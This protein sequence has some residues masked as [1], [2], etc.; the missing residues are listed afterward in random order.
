[1]TVWDQPPVYVCHRGRRLERATS[2]IVLMTAYHQLHHRQQQ[3]QQ[4]TDNEH[5]SSLITSNIPC[6]CWHRCWHRWRC[7]CSSSFS[8]RRIR[9]WWA[10]P[11]HG[12]LDRL[13]PEFCPSLHDG[14]PAGKQSRFIIQ[15]ISLC[16]WSSDRNTIGII[17]SRSIT[18]RVC[19]C[20]DVAVRLAA[21]DNLKIDRPTSVYGLA[22]QEFQ[23][24]YKITESFFES[25]FELLDFLLN[26]IVHQSSPNLAARVRVRAN[27][28][29][30]PV[31]F[32]ARIM[33][34][35]PLS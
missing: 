10:A 7:P 14:R 8:A 16:C 21:W 5:L 22:L 1:M 28:V 34:N 29:N 4:S 13:N 32:F 26:V 17:T 20:G 31:N 27:I 9:N 33:R 15:N 11:L 23:R 3:K 19:N 2:S 12:F 25:S 35:Q 18:S 24:G 30:Q 6:R